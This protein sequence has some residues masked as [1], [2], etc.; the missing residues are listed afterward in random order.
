MTR[1]SGLMRGGMAENVRPSELDPL[2]QCRTN[3]PEQAATRVTRR[4]FPALSTLAAVFV[5]PTYRDCGTDPARA[6]MEYAASPAAFPLVAPVFLIALVLAALCVRALARN[7][8]DRTT[9]KLGLGA[10]VMLVAS[11]LYTVAAQDGGLVYLLPMVPAIGLATVL[12]RTARG[13][14]PWVVWEH[15]LGAFGLLSLATFPSIVLLGDLFGW[16]TNNL[17]AGAWVYFA[18]LF[19]LLAVTLTPRLAA[20]RRRT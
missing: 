17:A 7:E 4:A 2:V 18:A 14:S 20:L 16:R 13:K 10:L 8:V 6:P 9:R 15:L 3:M 1:V 11:E 19:A 5:L 12:V